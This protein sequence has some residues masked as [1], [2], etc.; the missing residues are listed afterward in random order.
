MDMPP[1][2]TI[3]LFPCWEGAKNLIFCI[4]VIWELFRWY[5]LS[6]NDL[7]YA[8]RRSFNQSYTCSKGYKTPKAS[9]IISPYITTHHFL[10]WKRA[11]NLIFWMTYEGCYW[12]KWHSVSHK[13][14]LYAVRS[15]SN[16]L[17][18]YKW[19]YETLKRQWMSFLIAPH[20]ISPVEWVPQITC[21]AWNLRGVFGRND[22]MWTLRGLDTI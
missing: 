14:L 1:G 13:G 18:V 17:S 19:G 11:K 3:P 5:G 16:Y 2:S 12:Q 20:P 8:I 7:V 22:T 6:H 10:C 4:A 21:F 9:M 15:T